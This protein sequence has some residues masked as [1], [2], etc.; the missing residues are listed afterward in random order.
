M[1]LMCNL[2]SVLMLMLHSLPRACVNSFDLTAL[3]DS[4][5]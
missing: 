2:A 1:V 3:D 4:L 5:T